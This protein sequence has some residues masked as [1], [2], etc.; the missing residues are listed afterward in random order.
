MKCE[1]CI[2]FMHDYLDGDLAKENE[3]ILKE[4]L[5]SCEECQQH[6]K[7]LKKCI[8]FVQSTSHIEAPANFTMNVMAALP[9][10]NKR[11]KVNRWFKMHPF[12]T[13][14]S[15]FMILMFGSLMSSWTNSQDFSVSKHSGLMIQEETVVVPEGKTVNGDI[16]VRNGDIK[17]EGKVN[18]NVTVINGNQYLASAGQ[19]TGE[20]EELDQLF[21][22]V[23]Y[24]IKSNVTN[25]LYVF[26]EKK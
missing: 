9:K 1:Y 13:A 18:G 24:T 10:E 15:L 26:E 16:V 21:E 4:H 7:E 2:D 8:A 5:H 25:A 19:V 11:A 14:A 6:F 17:V 22:W 23:W 12:M 20:I 3:K